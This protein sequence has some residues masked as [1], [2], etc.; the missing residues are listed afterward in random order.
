MLLTLSI[1]GKFVLKVETKMRHSNG[2]KSAW[3]YLNGTQMTERQNWTQRIFSSRL[4]STR[5]KV[6]VTIKQ[7]CTAMLG[8]LLDCFV[9]FTTRNK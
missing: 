9:V 4:L 7:Q 2:S 8:S 6:R 1:W 3:L 5:L